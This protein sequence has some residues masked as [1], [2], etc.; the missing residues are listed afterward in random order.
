MDQK[1]YQFETVTESKRKIITE[2]IK[3]EDALGRENSFA[4]LFEFVPFL[5]H[6]EEIVFHVI[7]HDY[8][9][10]IAE[11]IINNFGAKDPNVK[12]FM[13]NVKYGNTYGMEFAENLGWTKTHEYDELLISEGTEMFS[14]YKKENPYYESIER[15]LK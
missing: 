9:K 8:A 1:I 7:D 6:S 2:F 15:K 3:K 4:G 14:L 5:D 12:Q 11:A 13:I 10:E